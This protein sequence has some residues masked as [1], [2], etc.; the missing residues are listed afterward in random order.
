MP[1][2]VAHDLAHAQAAARAAVAEGVALTVASPPFAARGMGVACWLAIVEATKQAVPS[3]D[4]AFSLDCADCPGDAHTAIA[5][6]AKQVMLDAH[7]PAHDAVRR[8]AEA[9]GAS[10]EAR[11]MPD[12][13]LAFVHDPEA[14]I[15]RL[16]QTTSQGG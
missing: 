1:T 15:R 10:L 3:A 4:I 7:V 16:I 5:F 8:L 13:D 2:V 14:A 12:L 11:S 9:E 6:G